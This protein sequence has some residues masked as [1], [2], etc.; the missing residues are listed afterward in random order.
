MIHISHQKEIELVKSKIVSRP[1]DIAKIHN[2]IFQISE[3][4]VI[5]SPIYE[6]VFR[7]IRT[8]EEK[9]IRIDGVTAKILS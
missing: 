2:E 3:H 5:Y 9:L 6:I 4:A 8:N 1:S 7:N